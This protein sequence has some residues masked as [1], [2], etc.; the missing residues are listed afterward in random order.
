MFWKKRKTTLKVPKIENGYITTSVPPFNV[1][2][3]MYFLMAEYAHQERYIR[4]RCE[5][6]GL[7]PT[8][9]L[10]AYFRKEIDVFSKHL[11][12]SRYVHKYFMN[13]NLSDKHVNC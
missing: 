4:C 7:T 3:R 2:R 6:L 1:K 8:E 11:E 9:S 5:E 12:L 13:S 10:L